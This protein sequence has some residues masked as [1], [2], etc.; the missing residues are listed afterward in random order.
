MKQLFRI[1][2]NGLVREN[3][4]LVL[5]IGICSSL[6]V[7]TAV[8]NGIGMGLSMT[9]VLLMSE[10]VISIFRKLIPDSIRIPVFIIIIAAFTTVIDY[11][12]K[13]WFPDLSKAMGVFIPLIVV[14][15][16]IMGRVEGFA[17]K[18]PVGNVVA[19]ALGM[20]LGYTWVLTG[21]SLIREILGCGA[22]LGMQVFPAS[23]QPILFFVLPP[24]GFFVFSLFIALNIYI[25]SRLK[26]PAVPVESGGSG[27]HCGSAGS[28]EG[29]DSPGTDGVRGRHGGQ[30]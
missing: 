14:N 29:R 25:K 20:G 19:D 28:A 10:L 13:A 30:A 7:T 23:Y 2:T 11:V 24:G 16:I 1:F 5:M 18:Q 8:A 21:I 3:P 9:F 12:L 22:I 27:G 4:L 26:A 17:S 6:A 15:C